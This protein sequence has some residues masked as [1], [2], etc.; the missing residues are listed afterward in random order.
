MNF[1]QF[2]EQIIEHTMATIYARKVGEEL[3]SKRSEESLQR[4]IRQDLRWD[5]ECL[6]LI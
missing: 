5:L 1:S 4:P 3:E 2:S 6:L